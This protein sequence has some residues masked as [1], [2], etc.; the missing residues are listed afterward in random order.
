MSTLVVLAAIG[1]ILVGRPTERD[2]RSHVHGKQCEDEGWEVM[3]GDLNE[4]GL[5]A[6]NK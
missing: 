4:T 6:M 5:A 1:G 2:Q 3:T